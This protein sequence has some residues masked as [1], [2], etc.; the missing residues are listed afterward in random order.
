MNDLTPYDLKEVH[1]TTK[2]T[3]G[4]PI[5]YKTTTTH[6]YSAVIPICGQC[7]FD[8]GQWKLRKNIIMGVLSII[9]LGIFASF[10]IGYF[11]GRYVNFFTAEV[12]AFWVIIIVGFASI[13]FVGEQLKK[14][15]KNIKSHTKFNT[16]WNNQKGKNEAVLYIKTQNSAN[17]ILYE[18]WMNNTLRERLG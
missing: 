4:A 1:S 15:N 8:H 18:D 13:I 5:R 3:G 11:S 2:K 10:L 17:W 6:T 9:V 14:Q 7:L 12:I 16:I